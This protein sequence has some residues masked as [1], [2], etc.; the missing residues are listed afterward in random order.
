MHI[1]LIEE[2]G[3]MALNKHSYAWE[4]DNDT[5]LEAISINISK[6][7]GLLQTA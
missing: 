5:L 7:D 6:R 1:G 2:I 3:R 4:I